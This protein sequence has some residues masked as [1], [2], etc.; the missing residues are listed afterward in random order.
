MSQP[1]SCTIDVAYGDPCPAGLPVSV[2]VPLPAGVPN[3]PAVLVLGCERPVDRRF[4]GRA[5]LLLD[6]HEY[7]SLR[8]LKPEP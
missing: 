8:S 4:L 6:R 5:G 2:G 7:P 1:V 3:D